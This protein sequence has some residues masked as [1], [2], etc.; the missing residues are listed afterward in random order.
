[1]HNYNGILLQYIA[2]YT[3]KSH[4]VSARKKH[5]QTVALPASDG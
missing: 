3:K 2:V 1:M 5:T 4:G